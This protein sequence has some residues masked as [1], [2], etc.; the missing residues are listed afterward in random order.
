M[1]LP[2]VPRIERTTVN[3]WDEQRVVDAVR[4]TGRKKLVVAGIST[5]VCLAFPA[6]SAVAAGYDS[7]AVSVCDSI[8]HTPD[9]DLSDRI[10]TPYRRRR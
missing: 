8:S 7:Y 2:G 4:A 3:A 10:M 5:D 9:T 6:M 1:I